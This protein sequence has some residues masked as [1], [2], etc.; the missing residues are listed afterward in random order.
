MDNLDF[1]FI[2]EYRKSDY[3]TQKF[4]AVTVFVFTRNFY[5]CFQIAAI[6]NFNSIDFSDIRYAFSYFNVTVFTAK[7]FYGF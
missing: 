4:T 7:F 5:R 2:M 3:V 6:F 1:I